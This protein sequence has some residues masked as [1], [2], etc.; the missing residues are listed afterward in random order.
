MSPLLGGI[1]E[2]YITGVV[3]INEDLFVVLDTDSI[4]SDKE[5]VKKETIPQES[6]L[7]E[8]FFIY[9]MNQIAELCG[10]HINP[11]NKAKFRDFYN[12]YAKENGITEMPKVSKEI[13]QAMVSKFNSLHTDEFWGN[14]YVDLFSQSVLNEVAKI[15]SDEVRILVG[16]RQ[17]V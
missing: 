12:E 2:R 14:H 3:G 9:F 4:F 10:I 5:K 8:E 6:D 15:C 13:A 1:N 11:S 16:L 7:S 17:W